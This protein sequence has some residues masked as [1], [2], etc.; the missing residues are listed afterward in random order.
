MKLPLEIRE[1][2]IGL[3]LVEAN[4]E[5]NVNISTFRS[6]N[7]HHFLCSNWNGLAHKSIQQRNDMT[8]ESKVE[9][10]R[11]ICPRIR[12]P[13]LSLS[14]RSREFSS[15]E[16]NLAIFRFPVR[17]D[18]PLFQ[19]SR[20]LRN[21]G[22]FSYLQFEVT[23]KE[24]GIGSVWADLRW[25]LY[26]VC[27][28]GQVGQNIRRMRIKW[29]ARTGER[30]FFEDNCATAM[31][32]LGLLANIN[33]LRELSVDLSGYSLVFDWYRLNRFR[34]CKGVAVRIE[35]P[36]SKVGNP[37]QN[38][39]LNLSSNLSAT[40]EAGFKELDVDAQHLSLLNPSRKRSGQEAEGHHPVGI[41]KRRVIDIDGIPSTQKQ[42]SPSNEPM[43]VVG[44]IS[45]ENMIVTESPPTKLRLATDLR[46][47]YSSPMLISS[48][49]LRTP[50]PANFSVVGTP[51]SISHMISPITP[52]FSSRDPTPKER[53][54]SSLNTYS[55]RTYEW[56]KYSDL[57]NYMHPSIPDSV[58]CWSGPSILLG[59]YRGTLRTTPYQLM[60]RCVIALYPLSLPTAQ[61]LPIMLALSKLRGL[62][63]VTVGV[64]EGEEGS[65]TTEVA[66]W[67]LSEWVKPREDEISEKEIR[68]QEAKALVLNARRREAS[69]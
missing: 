20:N 55:P 38:I 44:D 53:E 52:V 7:R 58:C 60:K 41:S 54:G 25:F 19:V 33:S 13:S 10:Y 22:A 8:E 15:L 24:A 23:E 66:E 67:L 48:S 30:P 29:S 32:T 21:N 45:L 68:F 31:H 6:W 69:N 59:T 11:E 47:Q 34:S 3:V 35:N 62:K 9:C 14:C 12:S 46:T 36:P 1:R 17:L 16:G 26:N 4:Q 61:E 37:P 63:D 50:P 40:G 56:T 28:N 2:I 42:D 65:V 51:P 39:T 49:P 64:A 18:H 43:E 5:T 27:L 57:C